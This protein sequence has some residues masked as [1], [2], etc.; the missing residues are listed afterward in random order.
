MKNHMEKGIANRLPT[1]VTKGYIK[2]ISYTTG[3]FCVTITVATRGSRSN[4]SP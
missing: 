1:G 2:M 4:N 3:L